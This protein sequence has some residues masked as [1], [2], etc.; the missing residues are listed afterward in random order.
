MYYPMRV[1]AGYDELIHYYFIGMESNVNDE[2]QINFNSV[3]AFRP[4]Y[5]ADK[6]VCVIKP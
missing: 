5:W 6:E 2:N 4:D 1:I 3:N